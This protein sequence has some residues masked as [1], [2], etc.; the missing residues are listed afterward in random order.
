MSFL[1]RFETPQAAYEWAS[2]NANFA[3]CYRRLKSGAHCVT[4]IDLIRIMDVPR[5]IERDFL[6]GGRK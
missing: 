6:V 5:A 2:L 1:D 3:C 4:F